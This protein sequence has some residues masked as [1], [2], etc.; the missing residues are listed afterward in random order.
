MKLKDQAQNKTER[1]SGLGYD[2]EILS[3][4]VI[5]NGCTRVE[6]FQVD[7]NIA[8]NQCLATIVRTKPDL[9]RMASSPVEIAIRWERP[10]DC[11]GLAITF[12]NPLLEVHSLKTMDTTLPGKGKK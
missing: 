10:A 11:E 8:D 1:I 7:H 3:F 6:D 2:G 12:Q 5:S 9:C 4:T